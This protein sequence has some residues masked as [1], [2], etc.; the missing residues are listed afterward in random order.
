MNEF[1]CH[2]W[3]S[4]CFFFFCFHCSMN[5]ILT[6]IILYQNNG[7]NRWWWWWCWFD[8]NI[9]PES[10]QLQVVCFSSSHTSHSPLSATNHSFI[11]YFYDQK[12]N[13]KLMQRFVA[14][15]LATIDRISMRWD[16]WELADRLLMAKDEIIIAAFVPQRHLF[17]N[18]WHTHMDAIFYTIY[19]NTIIICTRIMWPM[20]L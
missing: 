9:K 12:K 11:H 14:A 18:R 7:I 5:F 13:A 2:S 8:W 16:R 1:D 6:L 15:N 10:V 20:W 3:W 4:H 17:Q 19:D